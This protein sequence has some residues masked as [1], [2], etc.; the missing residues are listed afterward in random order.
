MKCCKWRSKTLR[1]RLRKYL[2]RRIGGNTTSLPFGTSWSP[3]FS[4]AGLDSRTQE[5]LLGSS[6]IGMLDALLVE[7]DRQDLE[8][9]VA[10][11]LSVYSYA[12]MPV[13]YPFP[14][15]RARYICCTAAAIYRR[16]SSLASILQ[17]SGDGRDARA[18]L[19]DTCLGIGP[20]QPSLFFRNVGHS[21]DLAI[22]D[23]HVLRFMSRIELIP[24][25]LPAVPGIADYQ[26]VEEVLGDYARRVGVTIGVLDIAIWVVMRIAQKEFSL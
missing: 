7:R 11:T 18:R 3:A 15:S 14:R 13:G 8:G 1:V 4:V 5:L 6:A 2:N 25:R 17:T 19:V 21:P 23:T 26:R 9:S 22:L 20:K 16:N 12:G 24:V 10:G